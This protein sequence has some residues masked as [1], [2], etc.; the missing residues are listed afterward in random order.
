[1]YLRILIGICERKIF[2]CKK[3]FFLK[4]SFKHYFF[5][6]LSRGMG[7][8]KWFW[9][10]RMIFERTNA[11]GLTSGRSRPR[12]NTKK[13]IGKTAFCN[14]GKPVPKPYKTWGILMILEPISRKELQ[15][16]WNPHYVY[17]HSVMPRRGVGK[18]SY[19]LGNVHF[20]TRQNA[21]A[22]PL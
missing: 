7:D 16:H 20:R 13:S 22:E 17:K 4:G 8:K 11:K 2:F 19:S 18:P 1:M 15:I 6:Y 12:Q 9:K 5:M 14:I 21:V 10:T 3:R